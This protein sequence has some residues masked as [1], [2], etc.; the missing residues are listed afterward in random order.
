[1]KINAEYSDI[2]Y[3]ADLATTGNS[4]VSY[5]YFGFDIKMID[6]SK[7]RH[8][9]CC[10]FISDITISKNL[11]YIIKQMDEMEAFKV[12]VKE[13]KELSSYQM[14]RINYKEKYFFY[15]SVDDTTSSP[16]ND[17]KV[18]YISFINSRYILLLILLIF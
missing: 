6:K 16:N 15:N 11:G 14:I 9:T 1:M 13:Q 2:C 4:G 17:G 18:T 12:E 5:V 8:K 10:L 7:V 3:K